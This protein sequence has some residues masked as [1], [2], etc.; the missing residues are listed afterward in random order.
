MLEII[1]V[2]AVL[3]ILQVLTCVVVMSIYTKQINSLEDELEDA[4][5]SIGDLAN[6]NFELRKSVDSHEEEYEQ[7]KEKYNS[8]LSYIHSGLSFSSEGGEYV[9]RRLDDIAIERAEEMIK[10]EPNGTNGEEVIKN[11]G[12]KTNVKRGWRA[13]WKVTPEMKKSILADKSTHEKIAKKF[14]I[15]RSRVGQIKRGEK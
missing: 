6:D 15:S 11:L 8:L 9:A 7:I 12:D 1:T 14:G 10:S 4:R 3:I 2:G 13:D 5:E